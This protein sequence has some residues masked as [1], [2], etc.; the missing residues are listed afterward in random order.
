VFSAN[1]ARPQ[2]GASRVRDEIRLIDEVGEISRS[3]FDAMVSDGV[4]HQS[5]R[6]VQV[7]FNHD[8]RPVTLHSSRTDLK[9]KPDLLVGLAIGQE[10]QHLPFSRTWAARKRITLIWGAV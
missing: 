6:R 5:S 3:G 4:S 8:A 10:A 7:K 1:G 9:N 2:E